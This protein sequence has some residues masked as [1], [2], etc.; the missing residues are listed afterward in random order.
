MR[1]TLLLSVIHTMAK[2][3]LVCA[4]VL[5]SIAGLV[6]E[7]LRV[8]EP[9]YDDETMWIGFFS[10]SYENNLPTW[11]SC[12]L[13]FLCAA[14]LA[15]I[16]FSDNAH[17][18]KFRRHWQSLACIFVYISL[19]EAVQLH[20]GLNLLFE[21]SGLLYFGWIIPFGAIVV[22]LGF[23]YQ[24]FLRQLP[25]KYRQRFILAGCLYVG[26]ALGMELPLGYWVDT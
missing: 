24:K 11:F 4:A 1:C 7:L 3:T 19:D 21:T 22:V 2:Y 26:G 5:L 23:V 16:S 9:F 8:R 17:A 10:L 14:M 12:Q 6:A 13:I 15:M 25:S 20:E 18:T